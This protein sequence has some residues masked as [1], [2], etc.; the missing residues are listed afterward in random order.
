MVIELEPSVLSHEEDGL[1]SF[2]FAQINLLSHDLSQLGVS[3][4]AFSPPEVIQKGA[5][6]HAILAMPYWVLPSL[7]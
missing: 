4:A 2:A 6:L 7:I 5:I 1:R 3:H